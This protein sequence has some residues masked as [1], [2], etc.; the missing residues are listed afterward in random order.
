M[1]QCI[2]NAIICYNAL[3]VSLPLSIEKIQFLKIF[4]CQPGASFLLH[5]PICVIVRFRASTIK[6]WTCNKKKLELSTKSTIQR[7]IN[8]RW[9][10]I[11]KLYSY[12]QY[13]SSDVSNKLYFFWFID[14]Y[15]HTYIYI[16][17]YTYMHIH[18]HNTVQ[19][20][21]NNP[22]QATTVKIQL[23]IDC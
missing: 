14:A 6:T 20:L 19:L 4:C 15:I 8:D 16:H 5:L 11:W 2:Q 1:S 18:A 9:T 3:A 17:I 7:C 10:G 12:Y 13:Q 23:V 21:R 22:R